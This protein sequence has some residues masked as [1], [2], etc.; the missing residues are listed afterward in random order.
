MAAITADSMRIEP[1]R[2]AGIRTQL[3]GLSINQRTLYP[4]IE[5]AAQYL[6]DELQTAGLVA[7][8]ATTSSAASPLGRTS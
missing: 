8:G 1:R 3:S 2:K 4:D 6:T 7:R 5:R